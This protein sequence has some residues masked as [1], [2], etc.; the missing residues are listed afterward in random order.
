MAIIAANQKLDDKIV[1][2]IQ[3]GQILAQD[4]IVSPFIMLLWQS[5]IYYLIR[6]FQLK[7][8]KRVYDFMLSL[9]EYA[10]IQLVIR[11]LT[12]NKS[13]IVK[14]Q[15]RNPAILSADSKGQA[16]LFN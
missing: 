4:L 1:W 9:L 11:E 6:K 8:N 7:R 3:F 16:K 12:M 14:M 10:F 2:L 5:F 13:R 15:Q